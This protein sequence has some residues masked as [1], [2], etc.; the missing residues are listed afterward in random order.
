MPLRQ[1]PA[2][3]LR[4]SPYGEVDKIV[5]L[6]TDEYGKIKGIAKGAQRSRQR[7]GNT[8]E[9]GSFVTASFFEKETGGL[10][11]LCHCDLIRPFTRLGEEIGRLARASYL[12]ELVSELTAERIENR[13]VFRLLVFSLERI[14]QSAGEEIDRVFEVRLLSHLGY[15]PQLERCLRCRAVPSGQRVFFAPEEGGVVCSACGPGLPGLIP[16]SLGSLRTLLL[17]QR[18]PLD[19]VRRLSFPPAILEESRQVLSLFLR[20][21]LGKELKSRK[22][23]QELASQGNLLTAS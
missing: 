7:F 3:I 2:I 12:I 17:A 23:L 10:V 21:H 22:F 1:T 5:T 4:A 20:Q 8:L 14:D 6:Y 9:I 18:I 16:V 13:A 11:R 19:K 15:Q